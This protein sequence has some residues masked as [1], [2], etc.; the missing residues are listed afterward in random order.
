MIR[1]DLLREFEED[2]KGSSPLV[3]VGEERSDEACR[4]DGPAPVPP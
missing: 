4:L 2:W 1:A 3:C